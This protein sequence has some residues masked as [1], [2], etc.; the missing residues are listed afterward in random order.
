MATG[1]PKK[2]TRT[3]MRNAGLLKEMRNAGLLKKGNLFRRFRFVDSGA[4]REVRSAAMPLTPD[5]AVA[6]VRE[7][8]IPAYLN[9]HP[10]TKSVIAAIPAGKANYHPADVARTALDL[11]WHIVSAEH[12][13]LKAVAAGAFDSAARALN[14]RRRLLTS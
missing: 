12:R 13:F 8:W 14:N 2:D 5:Q 7:L 11:A 6:V 4:Q 3:E 10:L 1:R 9:E